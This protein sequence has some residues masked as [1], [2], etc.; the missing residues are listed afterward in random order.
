MH[1][2]TLCVIGAG[3]E[4]QIE[5]GSVKIL[6]PPLRSIARTGMP[7]SIIFIKGHIKIFLSQAFVLKLRMN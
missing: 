1:G 2:F 4:L 5:S 7:D 3:I 6:A